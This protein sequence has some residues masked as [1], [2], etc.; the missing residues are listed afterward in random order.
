MGLTD[1]S[2]M[3]KEFYL[4]GVRAENER[5]IELLETQAQVTGYVEIELSKLI[6]LIKGEN[7]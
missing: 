5:I 4:A 7:K 2:M 6:A 1:Y 3:D